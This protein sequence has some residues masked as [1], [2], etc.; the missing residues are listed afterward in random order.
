MGSWGPRTELVSRS[1]PAP[2]RRR[3]RSRC[4][5]APRRQ[6]LL[7]R[8]NHAR[9]PPPASPPHPLCRAPPAY[10]PDRRPHLPTLHGAFAARNRN[11]SSHIKAEQNIECMQGEAVNEFGEVVNALFSF[12]SRSGQKPPTQEIWVVEIAPELGVDTLGRPSVRR[13]DF[14]EPSAYENR[15]KELLA[16]SPP[17]IN[18]SC[19]G[20]HD[21]RLLVIIE[22]PTKPSRA[23]RTSLNYSGVPKGVVDHG[24][25]ARYALVI[26]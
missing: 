1:T 24:W 20:V 19:Y 4:P 7:H 25:D 16:A 2:A 12:L 8:A 3:P 5:N 6:S 14:R 26:K 10:L 13:S 18:I 9:P 11:R 15:Y 17:W 22:L 21:G 23:N